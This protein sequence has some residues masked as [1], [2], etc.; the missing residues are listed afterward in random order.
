MAD[1]STS[2]AELDRPLAQRIGA[3]LRRE[4]TRAGLTQQAL[5]GERYTKAY[6]SALENGLVKPSMAALNY[7]AERLGIPATALLADP[8][9]R[10]T[11]LEA[12]LRLAS[13]DW[14]G[15]LDAY[16]ALVD[17]TP[18]AGERAEL[19]RGVAEAASRLDRSAEAVRA[20]T[21]AAELFDTLNRPL[22]AAWARYWHSFAVYQLEQP[23]DARRLLDR[24]DADLTSG[25]SPD[26]PDLRVRVAIARSVIEGHDE[27][28][29]RALASLESARAFAD[30][31]DDRRRATFYASLASSYQE[32]GDLEG[33][34]TAANQA[35]A[36]FRALEAELETYALENQLALAHL[37]LGN[38]DRAR[39]HAHASR[40]GFERLENDRLLAHA[41]ETEAQIDLAADDP[42]AALSHAGEAIELARRSDNGKAMVS[43]LITRGRALRAMGELGDAVTTLDEAVL[44]ARERGRRAQ[45][46][47]ALAELAETVAATG[48]LARAFALSQEAVRA[49]RM[50]PAP[51]GTSAAAI[52]QDR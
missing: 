29:E 32:L 39:A 37:G 31:L 1:R 21:E 28:P 45:L 24:I 43:A 18:P 6:V 35:L 48:D 4:R 20:A 52:A 49:N 27:Q 38:V 25:R 41:V 8:D 36:H 19:L 40:A 50:T 3:R 11:R 51:A 42:A 10:W 5:A 9:A 7:L 15:A 26:S 34:M 44:I 13:G 2:R 47:Q 12:D 17:A 22:D 33:A 30:Q 14:L 23:E 16:T 46:Q